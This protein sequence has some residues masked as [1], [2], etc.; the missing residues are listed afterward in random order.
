[1]RK[2]V[3]TPI[4]LVL[5][6]ALVATVAWSAAVPTYRAGSAHD[7]KAL[8]AYVIGDD[9]SAEALAALAV[10]PAVEV[11]C[12]AG[13]AGPYPCSNVDLL[14]LVP[15]AQLGGA[16]GN[17][18]WGYTAPDGTELALMGTGRSVAF[19]DVTDP[20]NP[21]VIGILPTASGDTQEADGAVWRDM[22]VNNGHAYIVSERGGGLQVVDL[23][24]L[25]A[26]P[27]AGGT[28]S[29]DV[30]FEGASSGPFSLDGFHNL[31]INTDTDMLYLVGVDSHNGR[32]MILVD[33]SEPKN[34]QIAGDFEHDYTIHDAQ[35]VIYQGPDADYNGDYVHPTEG[36]L[37]ADG[38]PTN[39]RQAEICFTFDED[40][41]NFVDVTDP[42]EAYIINT[43]AH[44]DGIVRNGAGSPGTENTVTGVYAHQGWLTDGHGFLLYNDELDELN[45][46]V[47]ALTGGTNTYYV[48][49]ADLDATDAD[50]TYNGADVHV[51]VH[52]TSLA[53]DH[54]MYVKGDLLFQANYTE[55][56]RVLEI[57]E[58][59]LRA[60]EGFTE[61]GFFDVDP[62][63]NAPGFAGTWN[64]FPFLESGTIIASSLDEGMYT[65][66]FNDP[67]EDATGVAT[68]LGL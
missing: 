42:A 7:A 41:V 9:V 40:V 39:G 37:D 30:T 13:V 47:G 35:C 65:L 20:V 29:A 2:P 66:R 14:G 58:D 15:L 8:G 24:A 33:I 51:W 32:G 62:G 43:I 61:V 28:I 68:D 63:V 1:M 27:T 53:T 3:N 48:E 26:N 44:N 59:A 5:L 45:T 12:V 16:A 4:N 17:D 56:I 64:V 25:I 31:V 10:D 6:V 21:A 60:G 50:G 18:S 22:K 23:D 38:D 55:G 67:R 11:P 57:D 54:N 49:I 52:P 34:P 36:D 19:V 46:R